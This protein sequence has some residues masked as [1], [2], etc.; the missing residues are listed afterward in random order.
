MVRIHSGCNI[1]LLESQISSFLKLPFKKAYLANADLEQNV[2][3]D[4]LKLISN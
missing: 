4:I 3:C 2:M 1:L